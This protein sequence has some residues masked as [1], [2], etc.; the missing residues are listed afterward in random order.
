MVITAWAMPGDSGIGDS[1]YPRAGNGG[2]DVQHY[3]LDIIADVSANRIE[4]VANITLQ[5]T[6][7]LSAFNLEFTPELD[8]LAVSVDDVAASYTRGISRELTITPMQTIP[9]E[10]TVTVLIRYEGTPDDGWINYGDGVMVFGEPTSA[11]GWYPVNEH[12]LDKAT[13]TLKITTDANLT[14]AAN[15]LLTQTLKQDNGLVTYVF[16]PRDPMASYLVTVAIGEFDIVTDESA[17]GIPIRNYFSV[18]VSNFA[19]RQFDQTAEMLDFYETVFGPY[20]FEVYGVV[21]HDT[22]IGAALETQTLSTFG[23]DMAGERVAAHELTHQWFGNSISLTDWRDIWLNE[24]FASYGEILWIEHDEGRAAADAAIRQWYTEMA[25]V[26]PARNVSA[27]TLASGLDS[28]DVD[29]IIL[30]N[31]QAS[32]AVE[33]LM[34]DFLSSSDLNTLIES[35][36]EEDISASDL[37][38]I[39]KRVE[40][41]P[42]PLRP[43]R[44]HAF[45]VLLGVA[46]QLGT[47]PPV[48]GDPGANRLFSG[49][50]YLRGGLTLHALRLEVG[51]EAFFNILREYTARYQN[52]NARTADFIAIAE[53]ISRQDLE[54]FF[55]AWLYQL[56]V[57]DIP[58]M[59][60]SWMET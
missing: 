36:P 20:P 7:D 59:N 29:G 49:V 51:D 5:A 2:Y 56:E 40:F 57:P 30:D 43:S 9:A 18:G 13:Y 1:Y 10:S 58:A 11:S 17:N 8:I 27:Q 21:V 15:G 26:T 3:D 25:N 53:E 34:G 45:G 52:G 24:G 4:G 6:H 47:L 22:F 16:E 35:L 23:V 32:T 38:D 19:R 39:I 54:S 28:L 48:P 42:T 12:P 46:D 33:T 37:F 55:N 31:A 44:L 50:V 60:L 14:V 41:E